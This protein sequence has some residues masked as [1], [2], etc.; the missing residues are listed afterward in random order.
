MITE[1]DFLEAGCDEASLHWEVD[2]QPFNDELRKAG[3]ALHK[4]WETAREELERLRA[5]VEK[6]TLH[7]P[8]AGQI[9]D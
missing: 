2:Q 8:F 4:Q 9:A 3:P 7:A 1:G 5:Q 6:L